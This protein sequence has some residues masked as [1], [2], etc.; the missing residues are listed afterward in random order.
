MEARSVSM[1]AAMEDARYI[2]ARDQPIDDALK[3]YG[4]Y[5]SIRPFHCK[6]KSENLQPSSIIRQILPCINWIQRYKWSFLLADL[7]AGITVGLAI[8]PQSIAYAA[9]AGLPLQYGL[10]SSFMGP[11]IYAL[12][13][14][15]KDVSIG[16]TTV[17]ALLVLEK[18]SQYP[19]ELAPTIAV[20][21][22]F[23][24]GCVQLAMGILRLG[25]FVDFVSLSVAKAFIA[26]A[27]LIIAVEQ[28]KGLLGLKFSSGGFPDF[29]YEIFNNIKETNYWDLIL[30]LSV[31]VVITLLKWVSP[32][33]GFVRTMWYDKVNYHFLRL[34]S[35]A[36]YAIAICA[37]GA[38]EG[39]LLSQ[40][41][42]AISLPTDIE[43]GLPPVEPPE[44]HIGNQTSWQSF[45][46]LGSSLVVF[47]LI[48]LL[49]LALIAKA[50]A[51]E[52]RYNVNSTQEFRAVGLA[53]LISSFFG[54]YPVTASF[55]RSA[56]N[57]QC[58]VKTQAAGIVTGAL[59]LLATAFITPWLHY[60]PKA[61]L[62]GVIICAVL[63]NVDLS[64][65]NKMWKIRKGDLFPYIVTFCACILLGI[66]Y[67]VLIGIFVSVALILFP[68]ARPTVAI[69][70]SGQDVIVTPYGNINFPAMGYLR[71]LI[72]AEIDKHEVSGQIVLDGSHWTDLDYSVA[73]RMKDLIKEIQLLGWQIN[74]S[75]MS[76]MVSGTF[77]VPTPRRTRRSESDSSLTASSRSTP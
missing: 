74:F 7:I 23:Y 75:E 14:T 18:I 26:A 69:Y 2:T 48:S 58:G 63:P 59:A 11:F 31:M 56:L 60:I 1:S 76:E 28:F 35:N 70:R 36:R 67:G 50:F 33:P 46:S 66:E 39:A 49:E 40:R 30:G 68:I 51:Q 6:C 34:I 15:S 21:L 25:F 37:A 45:K 65:L 10:Y 52:Y 20:L 32:K 13:G 41:I 29:V 57:A 22:T 17:M 54:S 27:S 73:A 3:I 77:D 19:T 24:T 38:V 43:P 4:A 5:H 53:N 72:I 16:P 44:F 9:I 12:L 62:A 71:K 55:S 47:P 61:A 42:S 8:V 64:V